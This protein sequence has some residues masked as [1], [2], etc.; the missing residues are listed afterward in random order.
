MVRVGYRAGVYAPA[1]PLNTLMATVRQML[2]RLKAFDRIKAAGDAMVANEQ[3]VLDINRSQLY[4]KGIGKDG[5]PLPPY[6]PDYAKR[7]PSR[8]FVDIYRTGRL[9]REM[10]LTIQGQ[11]YEISSRV[12]YSPYV[13]GKRP[14]IYG[15]TTEGKQQAWFIIRDSFVRELKDALQL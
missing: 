5:N 11:Q 9:Q 8:G 13:S 7:K 12:D 10:E 6:S 3:Q 4:D 14:T 1:L 15:L 2:D